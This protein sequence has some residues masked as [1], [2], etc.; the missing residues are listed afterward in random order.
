M[1]YC[2]LC[3]FG[4]KETNEYPCSNC[5]RGIVLEDHFEESAVVVAIKD[6]VKQLQPNIDPDNYGTEA[7]GYMKALRDVI[8]LLEGEDAFVAL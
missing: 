8:S 1:I 6:R 4:D 3:R 5:S 2:E 7:D